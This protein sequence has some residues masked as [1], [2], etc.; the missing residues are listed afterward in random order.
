LTDKVFIPAPNR[1]ELPGN[2][3]FD[4]AEICSALLQRNP[5]E[6][7]LSHLYQEF[8]FRQRMIAPDDLG[9]GFSALPESHRTLIDHAIAVRR[10][11]NHACVLEHIG[12]ALRRS[13]SS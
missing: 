1:F 5:A 4:D 11:R 12:Q 3:V 7:V 10:A 8:S 13:V 6:F 2:P 9:E